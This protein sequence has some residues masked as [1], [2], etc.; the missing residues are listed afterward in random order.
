MH[1]H[2]HIGREWYAVLTIWLGLMTVC[3]VFAFRIMTLL[4]RQHCAERLLRLHIAA[5]IGR[6]ARE[7]ARPPG[8]PA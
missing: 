6:A 8:E 4:Y 5:T 1:L 2:M 3:G 7:S